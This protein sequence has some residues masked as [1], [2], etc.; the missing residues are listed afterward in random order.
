MLDTETA[1][2]ITFTDDDAAPASVQWRWA[3][4][5]DDKWENLTFQGND[6]GGY[7]VVRGISAHKLGSLIELKATFAGQDDAGD[8]V[9]TIK[10]CPISYAY[11]VMRLNNSLLNQN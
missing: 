3:D 7:V 4:A 9:K 10:L 5:T 11:A 1:I 8:V 2:K 6:G